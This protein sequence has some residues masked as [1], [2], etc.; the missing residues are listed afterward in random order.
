MSDAK[1]NSLCRL[2]L[3][4]MVVL[5]AC[6]IA[7]GAQGGQ[8]ES[9]SIIREKI[10]D[11]NSRVV[12]VLRQ[13]ISDDSGAMDSEAAEKQRVA[14]EG[15]GTFHDTD[16]LAALVKLY[17]QA[18][19]H[20]PNRQAAAE[21]LATIGAKGSLTE[22]KKIVWDQQLPLTTRVKAAAALVEIGDDLGRQFLLLQ[23]DL[24]RLERKTMNTWYMDPVRGA[25]ERLDDRQ[26]MEALQKR[27]ADETGTM[28]NNITTLLTRMKINSEPV[29][30][31]KAMAAD[32]S[33]SKAEQRYAAIETLGYR[34]SI[35][36]IPL[37]ESLK[38]W[39][40]INQSPSYIQQRLLREYGEK[41]V[42]SIRQR[43]WKQLNEAVEKVQ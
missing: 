36:A 4:A 31:L 12:P 23:Y 27:V 25:I 38:P 42:I 29:E 21:A 32:P 43:C 35:D 7:I 15:L 2:V 6:R 1:S 14:I 28:R 19:A 20:K 9:L 40:T 17:Q 13:W 11:G 8:D 39:D 5:A 16:S 34:G 18:T 26:I 10:Q 41:S 3:T 24:Y 37:L 22:L 30:R 33:W